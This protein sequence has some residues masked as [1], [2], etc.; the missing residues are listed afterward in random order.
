M[1]GLGY[2]ASPGTNRHGGTS[3]GVRLTPMEVK[4]LQRIAL[5]LSSKEVAEDLVINKR[6][7]DFHLGNIYDKLEAKNRVQAI[8]TATRLGLIPFEPFFG[9]AQGES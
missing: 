4:V 9:H 1:H 6:T 8:R 7:V 5:G 3:A 2:M